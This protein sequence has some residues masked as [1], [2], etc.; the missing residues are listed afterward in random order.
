MALIVEKLR[1]DCRGKGMEWEGRKELG[2]GGKKELFPPKMITG[3][4]L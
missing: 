2:S 4:H 3:I 1:V